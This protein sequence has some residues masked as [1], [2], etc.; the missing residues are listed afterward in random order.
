MCYEYEL[1]R[2]VEKDNTIVVLPMTRN[3]LG[4]YFQLLIFTPN[5]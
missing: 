4:L 2:G 1:E 5:E 3:S